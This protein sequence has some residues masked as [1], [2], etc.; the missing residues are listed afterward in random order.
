MRPI[1]L[2]MSAFGPYPDKVELNLDVL[3]R[4]GLYLITGDTG[5]GK[6]T[7]FD[8]ISF[9]LFGAASGDIRETNSFRSKY[10]ADDTESFVELKFEYQGRIYIVKR[11]PEYLRAK[12]RGE[13]FVKTAAEAEL[14]MPDGRIVCKNREVTREIEAL[15]GI[16]RKQFAQIAMI[17]QGDFRKL[18]DADTNARIEIFR[19]I[20]KTA[21]YKKLQEE[22]KDDAKKTYGEIQDAK[23]SIEQY[24]EGVHCEPTNPLYPDYEKAPAGEMLIE[25]TI[26]LIEKIVA[27]DRV[28]LKEAKKQYEQADKALSAVRSNLE[29]YQKQENAKKDYESNK[30][31]LAKLEKDCEACEKEYQALEAKKGERERVAK[32]ITTLENL[33]PKFAKLN[34]FLEQ[35]ESTTV[36]KT[37][38]AARVQA[39][40]KSLEKDNESLQKKDECLKQLKDAGVNAAKLQASIE[41]LQQRLE[42]IAELEKK[43]AEH[44]RIARQLREKQQ[45]AQLAIEKHQE[46]QES[47]TE[48]NTAFLAEQAGILAQGLA[49]GEPCPVCGSK[50]HPRPAELSKKAPTE[51]D[52]KAAKQKAENT[53]ERAT[54]LASNAAALKA[55]E[56]DLKTEIKKRAEKLFESFEFEALSSLCLAQKEKTQA[57]KSD[58]ERELAAEKENEK[59]KAQLEKD[60][61]VLNEA[62]RQQQSDLTQGKAELAACAAAIE[63]KAKQITQLKN[64]LGFESQAA[65]EEKLNALKAESEAMQK[66]LESARAECEALKKQISELNGTQKGLEKAIQEAVTLNADELNETLTQAQEKKVTADKLKTNLF[67]AVKHNEQLLKSI[68]EKAADL[69]AIEARYTWLNTLSQT[70]NGNLS[71]KEKIRL[72]TYVQMMYFDRIIQRANTRLLV[73]TNGQ[74]ELLRRKEAGQ[75]QSQTGLDLDVLDHYNGSIRSVRSLSGGESFKASLAL[76][77]G[78]SDEIQCSAGGIEMDTMFI[79]EGFGS[80]DDDSLEAAVKVLV[81]MAGNRRLVGIISHVEKLKEKIDKKI[82]VYKTRQQDRI[83]STAGIVL[84]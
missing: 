23:K 42:E 80:L 30:E 56:A 17:A 81:G 78:L 1:T 43:A 16:N 13:G 70:V 41:K 7:I 35:L 37:E 32:R 76:A 63:E 66:A 52:V 49:D 20:F 50:A 83:G 69:L 29:L 8:A 61:P 40:E 64:E 53:N 9:A 45:E 54:Q 62:I 38:K 82:V 24:I 33:L 67:S 75:N 57:Q 4:S 25:D 28:S 19:Q 11:I 26:K 31:K 72:E 60:I 55:K 10:A 12:K 2:T 22:I 3:G 44:R 36:K 5:A 79:D 15:L 74:Y 47:F 84:E 34:A 14:T 73:M 68:Q 39:L 58:A 46:A 6:T 65:A 27:A 48:L 18:L 77:L 21:P 71:S 59:Q 51:E